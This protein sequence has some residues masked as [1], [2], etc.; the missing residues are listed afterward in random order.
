MYWLRGQ[1]RIGW[2]EEKIAKHLNEFW[3]H[4]LL[5]VVEDVVCLIKLELVVYMKSKDTGTVLVICTVLA[6]VKNP[7]FQ[8]RLAK[9]LNRDDKLID[10]LRSA[11]SG[12]TAGEIRAVS[13]EYYA[14]QCNWMNRKS[15]LASTFPQSSRVKWEEDATP[16]ILLCHE[17]IRVFEGTSMEKIKSDV[18]YALNVVWK[19]KALLGIVH[20]NG[21]Y[22]LKQ[23]TRS[24]WKSLFPWQLAGEITFGVISETFPDQIGYLGTK[25]L[26]RKV[27]EYEALG[28]PCEYFEVSM[29]MC[30][31]GKLK[32]RGERDLKYL[33]KR[34]EEYRKGS[35]LIGQR[36][37]DPSPSLYKKWLNELRRQD[38]T[39]KK[40]SVRGKKKRRAR[41]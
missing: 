13:G 2:E 27:K 34:V 7:L 38:E 39:A 6:W 17:I 15:G 10:F 35:I 30:M 21:P 1:E 16:L 25:T 23:C 40:K 31:T 37:L 18:N 3:E 32:I 8:V 20:G 11:W 28:F 33:A 14:Q 5:T 22:P 24:T 29:Y 4:G 19:Y 36:K 41:D 12:P 9:N 26:G